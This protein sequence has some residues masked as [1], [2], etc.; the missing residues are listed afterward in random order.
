MV[1]P[2]FMS[3]FPLLSEWASIT[4]HHH[5]EVLQVK[6]FSVLDRYFAGDVLSCDRSPLL[7]EGV[8]QLLLLK[9]NKCSYLILLRIIYVWLVTWG[10]IS[11]YKCIVF[12]NLF[13]LIKFKYEQSLSFFDFLK[14]NISNHLDRWIHYPD[15]VNYPEISDIPVKFVHCLPNVLQYIAK[16]HHSVICCC[17]IGWPKL[18]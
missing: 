5:E 9:I 16:L 7:P 4:W 3:S 18:F 17:R 1:V 10:T 2:N 15:P 12:L 14:I 6:D 13:L 8:E 11:S